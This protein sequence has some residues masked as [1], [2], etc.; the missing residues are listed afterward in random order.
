MTR[1]TASV[2]L[3]WRAVAAGAAWAALLT[4]GVVAAATPAPTY[5]VERV[6]TSGSNVTRLS[7]F[8]DGV[9]VLV[10]R[11]GD[12]QP[13]VLERQLD[14]VERKVMSQV[15]SECYPEIAA[16]AAPPKVPGSDTFELRL[17]PPEREPVIVKFPVAA[18]L[19]LG[20]GRLQ[21]ALDQLERKIGSQ[22]G[23]H[24]DLSSWEPAVGERVE[25][26][27]GRVLEVTE[28]VDST[29]GSMIRTVVVGAPVSQFW[30]VEELRRRAVRRLRP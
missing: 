22:R 24:E 4:A 2:P 8:R 21:Q 23:P 11:G 28:L 1:S 25:L 30:R 26:E 29:D 5:L 20:A 14:A 13:K 3:V 19:S 15:V 18:V 12:G 10:Q 16:L 27:D 9:A 7:V 17:A 6:V